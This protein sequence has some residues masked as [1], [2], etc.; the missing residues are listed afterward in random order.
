MRA[1]NAKG[2]KFVTCCE[3]FWWFV[4]KTMNLTTNEFHTSTG[5]TFDRFWMNIKDD[6]YWV[7]H[8]PFCGEKLEKYNA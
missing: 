1:I 8:C 3:P 4:D 5:E 2:Q 6:R 7:T